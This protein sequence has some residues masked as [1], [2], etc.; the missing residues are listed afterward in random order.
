MI[1]QQE[2]YERK[3]QF[4]MDPSDLF[5]AL[6]EGQK[7]VPLDARQ[8]FGYEMEH[9]P[10]AINIIQVL[11]AFRRYLTM[12]ES[13]QHLNKEVVYA[14]YCDGIGC[15][16]STKSALKLTKLGFKVKELMGG[17]AWWK[18]DGYETEG[19]HSAQGLAIKCA[20]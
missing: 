7:I 5:Q 13:T 18:F 9:I 12:W 17:L 8:A 19:S 1:T 15:N 4:E 2:F 16:A 14:C 3:L 20:C 11:S 6:E 10:G